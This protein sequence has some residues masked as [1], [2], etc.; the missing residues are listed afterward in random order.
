M[1]YTGFGFVMTLILQRIVVFFTIVE[2]ELNECWMIAK[3]IRFLRHISMVIHL[4]LRLFY[5]PVAHQQQVSEYR[6]D[7]AALSEMFVWV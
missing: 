6:T 3:N 1:H 2:I 5:V 7:V 4:C